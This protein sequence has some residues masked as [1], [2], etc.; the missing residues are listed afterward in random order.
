[1]GGPFLSYAGYSPPNK[2]K[3]ISILLVYFKSLQ[4]RRIDKTVG[5]KIY[6]KYSISSFIYVMECIL[7]SIIKLEIQKN[8]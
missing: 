8:K 2:Y 5:L 3:V 7:L 6:I 1:M 4:P